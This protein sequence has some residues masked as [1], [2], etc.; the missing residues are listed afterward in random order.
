MLKKLQ[1]GKSVPNQCSAW[2]ISAE[3]AAGQGSGH[4]VC[5]RDTDLRDTRAAMEKVWRAGETL[6]FR[7]KGPAK[8]KTGV[9]ER[10]PTCVREIEHR[11]NARLA[12]EGSVIC[13][14]AFNL[15]A[16]QG[17]HGQPPCDT[18][19]PARQK[20]PRLTSSRCSE[21]LSARARALSSPRRRARRFG[22]G[23]G[24]PEL[25]LMLV[26]NLVH[27]GRCWVFVFCFGAFLKRCRDQPRNSES[28][29]GNTMIAWDKA[30]GG[31]TGVG[32]LSVHSF[33]TDHRTD[34]EHD[35][36]APATA[37]GVLDGSPKQQAKRET[38]ASRGE[39]QSTAT[40]LE[41]LKENKESRPKQPLTIARIRP[42]A[43]IPSMAQR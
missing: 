22:C 21:S 40:Y 13:G 36:K 37:R 42:K 20:C 18:P 9:E 3:E 10:E 12:K 31:N 35:Q 34:P 41:H 33:P 1:D 38:G 39:Q 23:E 14:F 27:L 4:F 43:H 30:G 8:H 19:L 15:S 25:S 28:R 17:T 5:L 11:D 7:A 6:L 16:I 2:R 32:S 26:P 24:E 29:V